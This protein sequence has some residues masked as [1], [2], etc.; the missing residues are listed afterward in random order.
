MDECF[1]LS[2]NYTSRDLLPIAMA[3][4]EILPI[5]SY[6]AQ[7]KLSGLGIRIE[8]REIKSEQYGTSAGSSSE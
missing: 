1:V 8:K 6:G 3:V 5:A 2:A 7:Q 4:H